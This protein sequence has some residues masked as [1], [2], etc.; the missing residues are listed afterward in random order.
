[1]TRPEQPYG[2]IR[3]KSMQNFPPPRWPVLLSRLF[4]FSLGTDRSE[5]RGFTFKTL[6]HHVTIQ[7]IE[8]GYR[9]EPRKDGGLDF[10]SLDPECDGFVVA[11]TWVTDQEEREIAQRSP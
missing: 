10:Y 6:A 2:L 4:R 11:F 7:G 9:A 3:Y 1:M 5:A 8:P